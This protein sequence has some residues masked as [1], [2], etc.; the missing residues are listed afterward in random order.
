MSLKRLERGAMAGIEEHAA[1]FPGA[2]KAEF[3]EQAP[4]LQRERL[5]DV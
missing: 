1:Y 3:E 2:R 5:A 4:K